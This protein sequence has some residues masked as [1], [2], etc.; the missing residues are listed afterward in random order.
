MDKK[1]CVTLSDEDMAI[2]SGAETAK[3]NNVLKQ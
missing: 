3:K 2:F 1:R